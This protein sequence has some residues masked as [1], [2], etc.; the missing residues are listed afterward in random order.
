MTLNEIVKDILLIARGGKVSQSEV[1]TD[2]QVAFWV[3]TYRAML[4]KQ[5]YDK[6]AEIDRSYIQS[7]NCLELEDIDTAECPSLV[8]TNRVIMRTA[9]EVPKPIVTRKGL[10]FTFIGDVHGKPFQFTSEENI[11]YYVNRKYSGKDIYCFYRDRKLYI[12]GTAKLKYL[13]VRGVFEDPTELANYVNNCSQM[14]DYTIDDPYPIGANIIPV[15]KDLILV[16]EMKMEVQS[17]SDND[18]NANN[19]VSA[20]V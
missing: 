14:N 4:F 10:C 5:S 16:K 19:K 13:T 2:S 3:N 9:V 15:M 6:N 17:P 18:N 7:L 12:V 8:T 20:N 11:Y 1:I